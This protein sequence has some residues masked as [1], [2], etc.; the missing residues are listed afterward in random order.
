MNL[1]WTNLGL[2]YF[3][4]IAPGMGKHCDLGHI[5]DPNQR[6]R[7]GEENS[8]LNLSKQEVSLTFDL[9]V[10]PNHKGH[11][12]GP[13]VYQLDIILTAENTK[14]IRR[15]VEISIPGPWYSNESKMLSDGVG[16]RIL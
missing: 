9:M 12:I 11:I 7:V 8:N 6:Q 13:G 4:S 2:I 1:K 3:P 15:T 5:V 10:Y 14:P 16:V